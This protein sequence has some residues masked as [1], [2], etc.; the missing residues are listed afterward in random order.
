MTVDSNLH[1]RIIVSI[2]QRRN[3]VI[4]L[5]RNL[6]QA[7]LFMKPNPRTKLFLTEN[8]LLPRNQDRVDESGPGA[9][10]P[11]RF[12]FQIAEKQDDFAV[13]DDGDVVIGTRLGFSVEFR[14]PEIP[15]NVDRPLEI[16]GVDQEPLGSGFLPEVPWLELDFAG[17]LVFFVGAFD[18]DGEAVEEQ[19]LAPRDGDRTAL[20]GYFGAVD[21][22]ED[23]LA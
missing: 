1:L 21:R 17:V 12:V 16:T 15:E 2:D 7:P 23:V 13:A 5:N 9:R 8:M 4:T 3:S 22:N 14:E 11:V 19:I 18:R 20:T 10:L 6:M